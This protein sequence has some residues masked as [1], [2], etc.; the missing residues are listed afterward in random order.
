MAVKEGRVLY[1]GCT[2]A[3]PQLSH[4]D[5]PRVVLQMYNAP[6]TG[7]PPLQPASTLV[8]SLGHGQLECLSHEVSSCTDS[9]T[10]GYLWPTKRKKQAQTR[11]QSGINKRKS[12][13]S[14]SEH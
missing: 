4:L 14:K 1:C 10:R 3:Q 2:H 9:S 7:S 5:S 6:N 12:G 11:Q 13:V 8:Q